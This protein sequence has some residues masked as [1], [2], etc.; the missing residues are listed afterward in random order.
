MGHLQVSPEE[1]EDMKKKFMDC[2]RVL[3][4]IWLSGFVGTAKTTL[5]LVTFGL[6]MI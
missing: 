3:Q 6:N 2:H 4:S 1:A 5:P